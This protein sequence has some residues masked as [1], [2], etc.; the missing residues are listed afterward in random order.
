[1]ADIETDAFAS[2]TGIGTINSNDYAQ[3]ENRNMQLE[4]EN[5]ALKEMLKEL[6]ENCQSILQKSKD[7]KCYEDV[8][9]MFSKL[10]LDAEDYSLKQKNIGIKNKPTSFS[11]GFSTQASI[12][13]CSLLAHPESENRSPPPNIPTPLPQTGTRVTDLSKAQ[14]KST[15]CEHP[16]SQISQPNSSAVPTCPPED[17][18]DSRQSRTTEGDEPSSLMS[19]EPKQ[20]TSA[21]GNTSNTLTMGIPNPTNSSTLQSTSGNKQDQP[22]PKSKLVTDEMILFLKKK[23]VKSYKDFARALAFDSNEIYLM[24]N[25]ERDLEELPYLIMERWREKTGAGATPDNLIKALESIE[26]NDVVID[27]C[28]RFNLTNPKKSGTSGNVVTRKAKGTGHN[29]QLQYLQNQFVPNQHS[30]PN[31]PNYRPPSQQSFGAPIQQQPSVQGVHNQKEPGMHV[32]DGHFEHGPPKS[33]FHSSPKQIEILPLKEEHYRRP[34][35]TEPVV[36]THV[37]KETTKPVMNTKP[38]DRNPI[39]INASDRSLEASK[40]SFELLFEGF[41]KS[42]KN[43]AFRDF[44]KG[45]DKLKNFKQD[46]IRYMADEID[47]WDEKQRKQFQSSLKSNLKVSNVLEKWIDISFPG[48]P[49][50]SGKD[51]R[52]E[53][54]QDFVR[55][56]RRVKEKS[57]GREDVVV[58]MRKHIM[59]GIVGTQAHPG[60]NYTDL[61]YGVRF[62]VSRELNM[63]DDT[64]RYFKVKE[65]FVYNNIN[66]HKQFR[67]LFLTTWFFLSEY[68]YQGRVRFYYTYSSHAN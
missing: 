13:G 41:M 34:I 53:K 28:H 4:K 16:E 48:S 47:E 32:I 3:L 65:Y 26:R 67:I 35:Q 6:K 38:H 33:A 29:V 2:N 42:E 56:L 52:K 10:N 17:S 64:Y 66:G 55:T 61:P 36:Q 59:V 27:F 12:D 15:P 57:D 23:V 60:T 46:Y 18:V 30:H 14:P 37:D 43:K 25:K 8:M 54:F 11:S 40:S 39:P 45:L 9:K 49:K 20:E 50:L 51:E 21:H 68:F 24:E 63:L 22:M 62:N 31:H 5:K 7:R 44:K 19:H 1:M 58:E